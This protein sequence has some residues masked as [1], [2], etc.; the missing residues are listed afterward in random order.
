MNVGFIGVG[1]MGRGMAQRILSGGH[2]LAVYD[3]I[4]QATAEFASSGARVASSVADCCKE[5]EVVITML[6]EDAAV[7]DVASGSGGMCAS[8][9]AGAIHM[10]SG[11]YGIETIRFLEAEHAKAKQFVIA[12][13]VLGRPDLAASGQLGLIPAGPAEAL[14]RCEP[15]LQLIG[16]RLFHAGAKPESASAIKLANNAVLGCAITA[17]A[18]GFSLIRKHGVE[19][20]VLY[21]VMT[22]GLFAGGIAY[23]GYGK[24]MVEGTYDK[25]GSPI[26]IGMKDANLIAAAANVARVPMPSHDV[27]IQRLLG[28]IAHGDANLDQAALAREQARASGLE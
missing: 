21:D 22:E 19:P 6:A 23:V 1:R 9:P 4:P 26:T 17:L 28:A 14:Q 7:R 8:L 11:T 10:A 12:V 16:R 20:Q 27:Y 13:P 25:V 18:E 15:L 2:D 3:A 5:R 24:T